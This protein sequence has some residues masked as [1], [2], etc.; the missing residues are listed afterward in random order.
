LLAHIPAE[1]FQGDS[2]RL[3]DIWGWTDPAS[4]KEYAL[5]GLIDGVAFV[6]ISTPTEPVI[7]GKLEESI[8]TGAPAPATERKYHLLHDEG[9]SAW[10]DFKVYLNYLFVVSD[11]Q[12][13]GMQVFDLTRLRNVSN[14]PASFTED[15]HYTGFG[16]AH[17]I[18][19]NTETGF[20]YAVGS[21]TYGGGLHIVDI[22][23]P[24]QP[25]FAGMH[26][27]STVGHQL[28]GYVHDTQCV[29]YQG[30]D[31]DYQGEEI[32]FNSSE[33]HLAIANVSNKD[34][35]YTI[36]TAGYE[37]VEYSHQGW[38]TEDHNYFL[39]DDE[40]DEIFSNGTM[41]T[42]TI[43]WDVRDL[44]NPQVV[45]IYEASTFSSDHNLYIKEGRVY[46]AN[47]TSGLRILN[48][49]NIASGELSEIAYFDTY[50]QSDAAGTEGA[51]SNYPFFHSG[52]V[53]VSD[54]SNGL[55][56][57]RPRVK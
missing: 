10:R 11:N 14:P 46:Q 5:V 17:N 48:I 40:L 26:S 23:N 12:P 19:I 54:I 36:A 18:A 32:C 13:H 8:D 33:T 43:I 55:F 50:P 41:H 35:T 47:Y 56:I 45:N 49:D 38:L 53:I 28:T 44:D 34:S 7:I 1:E 25:E 39:M 4:G 57:L 21:D 3:N 29:I 15:A 52:V 9:K 37:G 6:D 30:E 24:L 31:A 51:W 42:R 2:L 20:A 27:D 22:S 16:P